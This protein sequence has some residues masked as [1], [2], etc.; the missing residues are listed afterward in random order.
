VPW[1]HQ[2]PQRSADPRFP[3]EHRLRVVARGANGQPRTY[4]LATSSTQNTAYWR[5]ALAILGL[6][7]ATLAD[8]LRSARNSASARITSVSIAT[9]AA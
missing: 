6:D 3:G 9:S 5:L 7:V 1:Q 2:H 4:R 8:E